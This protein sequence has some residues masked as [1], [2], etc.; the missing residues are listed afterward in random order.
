MN[1]EGNVDVTDEVKRMGETFERFVKADWRKQSKWGIKPS[2]VRVLLS[3]KEISRES[4]HGVNISQISK[5]LFVTSPTVTQMVKS[6]S[7]SGLIERS[8]DSL[9]RRIAD[10][11]LTEKGEIIA[12]KAMDRYNRILSGLIKTLGKEKSETLNALLNEAYI[13]FDEASKM[14]TE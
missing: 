12:Q 10:I 7:S 13:Y 1:H 8:I 9:D 5:M 3:I 14:E 6:L 11:R 2:E 4:L